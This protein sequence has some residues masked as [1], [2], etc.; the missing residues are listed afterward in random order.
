MQQ[1]PRARKVLRELYPAA[2]AAGVA[3]PDQLQSSKGAARLTADDSIA[4]V[5]ATACDCRASACALASPSPFPCPLPFPSALVTPGAARPSDRVRIESLSAFT[6]GA[7]DWSGIWRI[8]ESD[9]PGGGES[10]R[11]FR[12]P[13]ALPFPG[14]LSATAEKAELPGL[15]ETGS[16]PGGVSWPGL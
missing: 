10:A 16:R 11:S 1:L 7:L 5:A 3:K 9:K 12:D 14:T 6:S 4:C 15:E 13:K 2:L 8:F